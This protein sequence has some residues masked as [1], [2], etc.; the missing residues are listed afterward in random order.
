MQATDSKFGFLP[1]EKTRIIIIYILIIAFTLICFA[2]SILIGQSYVVLAGLGVVAYIL[3]LR[4]GVDADHISAI[5]N[6]TRKLLQEGK[7]PLTVGT[8]FS[9]G[10]ST[11]VIAMTI[12]FVFATKAVVASL[13]FFQ[14]IGA[15]IGTLISGIFLFLIGTINVV[16][17]KDTYSVFKALKVGKLGEHELEKALN[18]KGF[19]TKK[20]AKL[21]SIVNSSWQTYIIGLLFGLGFDT[22]TEVALIALSVGVGVESGVPIWMVLVLPLMFTA[23]MVIVDTSDGISMRLAYNWAFLKPIRK[24][25]Y[26]LTITAISVLVAFL[27]GGIEL[28]QV[29]SNQLHWGGFWNVLRNADFETIGFLII[30]VFI[31][32]W[33]VAVVYYKRKGFELKSSA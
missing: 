18:T 8:W 6:T 2:A 16:I 17:I 24:L 10:H 23:G 20:F 19:M 25:Y 31:V 15:T 3:G 11:I 4:H 27:V 32:S 22:A 21:F 12:V 30:A 14:T 5:D 29:L 26:N 28:F 9:L 13:P 1:H 33:L 7:H